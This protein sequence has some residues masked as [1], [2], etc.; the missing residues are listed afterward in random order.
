MGL[1]RIAWT[2]LSYVPVTGK[3]FLYMI[4]FNLYNSLRILRC[5]SL[6]FFISEEIGL[7]WLS[8]LPKVCL[9]PKHL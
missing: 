3:P 5:Y 8:D 4:P 7:E 2:V 6:H 9:S 1:M